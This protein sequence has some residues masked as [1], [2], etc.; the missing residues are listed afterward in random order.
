MITIKILNANQCSIDGSLK[1][2][3]KLYEELSIRHPNAFHIRMYS[4]GNWDGIVHYL[5]KT[6]KFSV[7]L[8]PMVYNRLLELKQRVEIIDFRE[9]IN[10]KPVVP[11]MVGNKKVRDIQKEAIEAV[12]TNKVGGMPFYIGVQD[13]AVNFGKSLI[14]AGLFLA[15][16]KKLKTLLLTNDSDWLEQAKT[17]F[18]ELL[19]DD[20]ITFIRGGGVKNWNMFSIGMVQSL[21]KNL[22]VYQWELSKIDM[23]LIDE[24][25]LI[26]NKTYKEVIRHMYNTRVRVGL[27]G[28]VYLSKLKKDLIHK[29]NVKSFIGDVL[30]EVRI[31]DMVE[32]KHSTPVIVKLIPT[33]YNEGRVNLGPYPE[34][35]DTVITNNKK[36]YKISL[37]RAVRNLN[38]GRIPMLVVTK[39][40]KHCE[41]LY[42]YYKDALGKGISIAYV[43]SGVNTKTRNKIMKDFRAGDI[44][45]LISNSFIA[46]GKNFPL[47]RYLQNTASMDSNEKTIQLLGRLVRTHESKSKTYLDDIQFNGK[48]LTR[49]AKHRKNYYLKENLTV[50]KVKA[51]YPINTRS[52]K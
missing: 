48:Y 32:S 5:S 23:V 17:E 20:N 35:Y 3:N 40:I 37:Q 34:E 2:L 43:H 4:K 22:D 9:P 31:K 49:H 19:P 15:F 6:G 42:K 52:T 29:M 38:R 16:K 27:S 12:I 7:G 51:K 28:T 18:P 50:I 41:L 8:L 36:A 30:K 14:M 47:L 11:K 45:I 46:R 25:D 24:C 1:V 10:V 13:L 26:D 44:D 21:A 33:S 39:Y